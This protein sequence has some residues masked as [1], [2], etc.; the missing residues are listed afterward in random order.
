M[1][2]ERG[3]SLSR[4]LPRSPRFALSVA[5][6]PLPRTALILFLA[7]LSAACGGVPALLNGQLTVVAQQHD[8][9]ALSDA[10]EQLIA[11]GKDTATDRAFAYQEARK[12]PE[13]SSAAYAFARAAITGRYV[14]THGLAGL[15]HIAEVETWARRS[16]ELDPGYRGGAAT[17]MLGTLYVLVPATMLAHGDSEE[18]L[19]LLE[20]LVKLHPEVPE[21]HLR[22]AEA[23]VALGDPA[24]AAPHLCFCLAARASLRPDEQ[25]LLDRV[26]KDAEMPPCP[27]GAPH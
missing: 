2:S 15:R 19:S 23:L 3:G 25:G 22:L 24:P 1:K 7:S 9:I 4:S 14:Q 21:N 8:T 20:G 10:L 13:E 6:V 11:A 26:V 5:S 16:R 17:R 12:G 18:G 27:S